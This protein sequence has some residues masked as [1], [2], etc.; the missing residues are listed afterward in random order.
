M[1][2]RILV[3]LKRS[4]Y[5]LYVACH[6]EPNFT[7]FLSQERVV[8]NL[9]DRHK[10]HEHS[11]RRC[12][13]ILTQR[14]LIWDCLLRDELKTQI[15]NADLIVTVGGD[16]T[17]LQASH[18]V[19]SSIPILGLNSDPTWKDEVEVQIEQFD[20]TRSRGFLCLA[21]AENFGEVL[22]EILEDKRHSMELKR[23]SV[24]SNGSQ[25]LPPAL[26]DVLLAHPN[27]ASVSRCS[28][29]VD[30]EDGD[31]VTPFIHSRSSGLRIC[32]GAGSTAAMQSA[33][34]YPMRMLSQDLQYML[35]DFGRHM[36][37]TEYKQE[38]LYN[39]KR[40]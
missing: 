32:T 25:I 19:D 10:V 26:N 33:G 9:L 17:L 30:K 27:P 8:G 22:D 16:G 29:R 7:S 37:T 23:I 39:F 24:S 3:L 18:Y 35:S 31:P 20:A 15:H 21:T 11:V 5:D 34:G 40:S 14:G 36:T 2:K 38:R 1:K 4:A 28:F 13:D 6:Q 12:K